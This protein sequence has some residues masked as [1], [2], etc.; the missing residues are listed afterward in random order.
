MAVAHLAS[1]AGSVA[2]K[3]RSER[4]SRRRATWPDGNVT[5]LIVK[6]SRVTWLV[7]AT[8]MALVSGVILAATFFINV[9][10]EPLPRG[11]GGSGGAGA[12]HVGAGGD[13]RVGTHRGGHHGAAV[14]PGP[15]TVAAHP[16]AAGMAASLGVQGPAPVVEP[17]AGSPTTQQYADTLQRL[18]A[19]LHSR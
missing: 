7:L 10:D 5:Y 16:A 19:A 6:L 1:W 4:N 13:H 12:V 15:A 11:G 3:P 18:N 14:T 17:N 9:G 2:T 8:A